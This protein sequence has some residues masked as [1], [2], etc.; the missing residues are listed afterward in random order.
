MSSI[1]IFARAGAKGIL[2]ADPQEPPA[3]DVKGLPVKWVKT[4]VTSWDSISNAFQ[5]AADT[6]K[7]IDMVFVNAGIGEKPHLFVTNKDKSGKPE[8]PDWAVINVKSVPAATAFA[9][10]LT[11]PVSL[12]PSILLS[13][14]CSGFEN[15]ASRAVLS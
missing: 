8:E 11:S 13:S 12:V 3:A 10:E 5:V 9:L 4:D 2:I 15:W 6:Y 1:Q 14:P 7:T